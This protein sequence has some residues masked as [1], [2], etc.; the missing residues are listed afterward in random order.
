MTTC[1]FHFEIMVQSTPKQF[2]DTC[3]L[4]LQNETCY[5]LWF[6]VE[7]FL[8][9]APTFLTYGT[10]ALILGISKVVSPLYIFGILTMGLQV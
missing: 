2:V 5:Q 7:C 8:H 4:D 9:L 3:D 1:L 6:I 10:T